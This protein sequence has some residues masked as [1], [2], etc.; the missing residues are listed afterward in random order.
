MNAAEEKR[1]KWFII[2][3]VIVGAA[4][5]FRSSI[6]V[7]SVYQLYLG[8]ILLAVIEAAAGAARASCEKKFL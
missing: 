7:P 5:G 8:V 6:S 2:T 3:G 4:A 1:M